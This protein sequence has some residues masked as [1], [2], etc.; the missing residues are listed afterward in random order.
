[1]IT[2]NNFKCESPRTSNHRIENR[3]DYSE[4]WCGRKGKYILNCDGCKYNKVE[5]QIRTD[6]N[7]YLDWLAARGLK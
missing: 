5:A 4:M 6:P 3:G 1:M 7:N 2:W